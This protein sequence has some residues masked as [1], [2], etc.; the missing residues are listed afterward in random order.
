MN[1]DP[2]T[3][4]STLCRIA[5]ERQLQDKKWG[6]Q[7]HP[8]HDPTLSDR[9]PQRLAEEYEI[10]TAARAK[11]ICQEAF[12][13]GQGSWATILI[14]EVGEAIGAGT[15]EDLKQELVQVAA[16]CVAWI[17]CIERRHWKA[18]V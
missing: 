17:Q 11:F 12:R 8:D 10:P 6:E 15:P 1:A 18:V 4:W 13:K 16:V 9:E 3:L 2:I 14:E 5:G 7:N